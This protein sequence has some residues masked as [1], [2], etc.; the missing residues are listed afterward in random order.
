MVKISSLAKVEFLRRGQPL[1]ESV[2]HCIVCNGTARDPLVSVEGWEVMCCR[3]CGLGIL[4]PRP[5]AHS[6][7]AL[8]DDTYFTTRQAAPLQAAAVKKAIRGAGRMLRSLKR[9]KSGGRLLDIGC[10]AGYFLAA[11][12]EAGF[13]VRGVEP[14]SWGIDV[15]RGIL[16]L[17]VDQVS[18]ESVEFAPESFDLVN[19]SHVLEHVSSPLVLLAKVRQWLVSDGIVVI[20]L[21]NHASYDTR[22]YGAH[23]YGWQVPYH[24]WHFTPSTL[25]RLLSE[26]GFRVEACR[27]DSSRYIKEEWKG[28]PV[29]RWFRHL[30][31]RFYA[32]RDMTVIAS[33]G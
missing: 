33:R 4:D 11:A 10:G 5:T 28:I 26:H 8:Y 17:P 13:D 23:W 24:L 9:Y 7:S 27:L 12:R 30:I 29:V 15:A 3:D 18:I 21:P 2:S 22:R 19:L 25:T 32:G 14:S 6:L 1:F 31:A 20:T 16:N